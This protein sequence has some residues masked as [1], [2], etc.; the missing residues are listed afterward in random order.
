VVASGEDTATILHELRNR[1]GLGLRQVTHTLGVTAEQK[2][3]VIA[4]D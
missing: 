1:I 2:D 3:Y 4:V